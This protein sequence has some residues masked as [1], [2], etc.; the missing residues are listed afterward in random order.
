M[1]IIV[2]RTRT[3][4]KAGLDFDCFGK[5]LAGKLPKAIKVKE[6]LGELTEWAENEIFEGIRKRVTRRNFV[7]FQVEIHI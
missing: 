6:I 4:F 3:L 5:I 2:A 1:F 7:H